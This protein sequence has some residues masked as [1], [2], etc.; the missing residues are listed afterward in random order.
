V[1]STLPA[2]V[3]LV[4]DDEREVR[5]LFVEVLNAD[6]MRSVQA[7]T[8][9]DAWALLENGLVP[10]AVLLDLQ[11]PGMGGLGFLLQLRADPRYSALPVTIVTGDYYVAQTT[12]A[13]VEALGA[14]VG[15]KPLA[16]DEILSLARRMIDSPALGMPSTPDWARP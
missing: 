5:E 15:F 3:V 10:S 13:A 6:G 8:A 4:V 1:G 16:F 9:E 11:M 14:A 2:P 7:S 12:R